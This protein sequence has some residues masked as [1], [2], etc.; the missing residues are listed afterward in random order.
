MVP[1]NMHPGLQLL[2]LF[3]SSAPKRYIFRDPDT[4]RKFQAG[5]KQSLATQIVSYRA[6]NGL[7]P[8]KH[9]DMVLEHYWATLPENAHIS[10]KA[11]ALKRGFLAYLKGGIAV[12]DN[13]WYGEEH[14]VGQAIANE[15][16]RQCSTCRFNVFP[17]KGPFIKWTD[18]IAENSIGDKVTP[19]DSELGNC[20]VCTCVLRAKVWFKGDMKLSEEER[21]K[22]RTVGCWQL[23]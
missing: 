20:A 10:E 4:N 9:L 2:R 14:M 21:A 8:I 13:I 22:M 3:P 11:P 19:Y 16:A 5:T 1:G 18:M 23:K 6:Q 15:R 12:I 17:D 7:H